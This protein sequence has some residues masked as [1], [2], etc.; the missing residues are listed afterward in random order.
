VEEKGANFC[1][2]LDGEPLLSALYIYTA[3]L[4]EL[5]TILKVSAQAG[6]S[7]AVHTNS[8]ES[9]AQDDNVQE[10]RDARCVISNDNSQSQEV[11]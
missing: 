6:Q 2:S 8:V 7:G 3:T 1:K 4:N 9:T 10:V 11:N 5:K